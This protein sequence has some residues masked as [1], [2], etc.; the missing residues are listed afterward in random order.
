VQPL[1]E[2]GHHNAKKALAEPR[3]KIT[4]SLVYFFT[5]IIFFHRVLTNS[6]VLL[7]LNLIHILK[8]QSSEKFPS[9]LY[10]YSSQFGF[11]FTN[12]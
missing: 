12:S 8:E 7:F 4:V 6:L 5:V 2:G 3:D 1:T 11:G 10:L 9:S